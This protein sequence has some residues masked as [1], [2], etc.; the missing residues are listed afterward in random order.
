MIE[1][2][3]A[4]KVRIEDLVEGEFVRTEGKMEPNYVITPLNEIVS[5]AR[6][7]GVV[8]SKFISDDENYINITLDDSTETLS[9]RAFRDV[10]VLKEVGVGETVD[11]I[12]KA[13]EY[14]GEIYL[15]AE[16]LAKV[17]DPNWELVR[18]LELAEKDREM[19][20]RA[21][22]EEEEEAVAEGASTRVKELIQAKDE[23]E[24]VKYITIARNAG[25]KE[26]ELDNIINKLL[27]E[28]EI[29]EPK[30]GRFKLM[31]E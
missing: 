2:R 26:N 24:G 18:R 16:A 23:G 19:P 21:E 3:T 15:L 1:R 9:V 17:E 25:L 11:I 20:Y 13:R 31:K 5:R 10:E 22:A 4:L 14:Q 29:Y 8:A 7:M 28:G 6:V 27:I 12:G 30:I